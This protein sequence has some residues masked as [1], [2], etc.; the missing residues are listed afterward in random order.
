MNIYRLA[1]SLE[2]KDSFSCI[3]SLL[4]FSIVPPQIMNIS[5]DITVNE[6]SS[7]TLL[8]LAIGRPEPTVTWRHLS[9]KGKACTY[10]TFLE[11]VFWRLDSIVHQSFRNQ[12]TMLFDTRVMSEQRPHPSVTEYSIPEGRFIDN[13]YWIIISVLFM[14]LA[15]FCVPDYEE[16]RCR[17]N[18]FQ[19]SNWF[20]KVKIGWVSWWV[21]LLE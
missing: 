1:P 12:K 13:L 3:Y 20:L 11:P 6:G 10:R 19:Q 21:V 9:V 7:V 18:N 14:T 4:C 2:C 16:E 5:S 17:K 15:D 8:C